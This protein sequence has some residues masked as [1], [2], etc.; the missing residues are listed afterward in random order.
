L[1]RLESSP[2]R[3][4]IS[5]ILLPDFFAISVLF[6]CAQRLRVEPRVQGVAHCSFR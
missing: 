1:K 6:A 4:S 3:R 5:Q 2:N